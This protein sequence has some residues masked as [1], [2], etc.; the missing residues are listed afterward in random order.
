MTRSSWYMT[1]SRPPIPSASGLEASTDTRM[2]VPGALVLE[3]PSLTEDTPALTA[4]CAP[5]CQ[6]TTRPPALTQSWSAR[7][8]L[9]PRAWTA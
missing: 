6:A 8:P 3:P 9:A 7:L 1:Q 5:P 2:S 4:T